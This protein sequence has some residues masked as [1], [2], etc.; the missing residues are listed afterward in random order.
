[1]V[2][3]K[4]AISLKH[5]GIVLAMPE[6]HCNMQCQTSAQMELPVISPI[7]CQFTKQLLEKGGCGGG[8]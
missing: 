2:L 1:M 6:L 5:L 8:G 7:H 3:E 4:N